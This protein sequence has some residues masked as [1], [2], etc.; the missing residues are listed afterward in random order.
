MNRL[1]NG[2]LTILCLFIS[3]SI[4]GQ[5]HTG[6]R[7]LDSLLDKLAITT[8][9]K[10][11]IGLLD[12]ISFSFSRVDPNQGVKYALEAL[13]LSEKLKLEKDIASAHGEL[14]INYAALAKYT[15][16]FHHDSIALAMY[17]RMGN[18]PSIAGAL[19]NL[20]TLYLSQ[21]NYSKSL[22]YGFRAL[23]VNEE[24]DDEINKAIILEN[25]GTIYFEQK[26]YDEAIAYYSK[27]V[28]SYKKLKNTEG[29]ARS[30]ANEGIVQ[31][32]IGQ[33]EQALRSHMEALKINREL[34]IR[35]S[36]Q[37]NLVNIG[38]VYCHM[39]RFADALTYQFEALRLSEELGSTSSIAINAGNI[40]ETYYFIV[41]DSSHTPPGGKLVKNTRN[42][43]LQEAIRHL[44]RSVNLCKDISFWGPFI[45]F[46]EYLSKA[47]ALSGNYAKAYTTYKEYTGIKDSIFSQQNKILISDL[48]TER[49]LL[50]KEKDIIVKNK[51]LEIVKLQNIN[52]RNENIF[53]IAGIIFLLTILAFLL[54]ELHRRNKT[55]Q[56]IKL[57]NGDLEKNI[58]QLERVNKDLEA[59]SYSVSHDLHAPLR[60]VGGYVKMLY[61]DHGSKL[62]EEGNRIIQTIKYNTSR[63][64]LLIDELLAFSK[65]GQKVLHKKEIDMNSLLR[66]VVE[67]INN[68]MKHKAEIRIDK[69]PP[70][71]ADYNLLYQVVFNL[72]SNAVKYSSKKDRP[73]V[74]IHSRK[75]MDEVVFSVKDN[76]SGFDMAYADKLFE[77]FQRLHTEEEFEGNGVGLALVERVITKHGGKVWAEGIPDEGATFYFSLPA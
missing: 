54:W 4:S 35:Q 45:E 67:D 47:Y 75:L 12:Q 58:L 34:D 6:N 41:T 9:A 5:D 50:L 20:S 44:E 22:E 18:K 38:I 19:A 16:A 10:I 28:K 51:L 23:R 60:A 43:N 49:E 25:I 2:C 76:G 17:T 8:E 69:M 27:A 64:G 11:R 56:K 55:A 29:M 36:M 53:L 42:A 1:L 72:V 33:Y 77:V 7:H 70:V 73:I 66:T 24:L 31:D 21:S 3:T 26:N 68:S 62:N 46:S 61:E 37:I 59:F 32:A 13:Q 30:L 57:L 65:L 63:M 74:D 48:E 15:K 39:Q 71:I 40:G 14:G 52:K